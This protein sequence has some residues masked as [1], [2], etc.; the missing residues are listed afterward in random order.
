M[1][2]ERAALLKSKGTRYQLLVHLS[3]LSQPSPPTYAL[4]FLH[5]AGC[6][7]SYRPVPCPDLLL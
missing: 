2:G 4:S 1:V 3:L 7:E 6:L 5:R